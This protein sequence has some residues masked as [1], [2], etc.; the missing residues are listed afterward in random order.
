M[1]YL[2]NGKGAE[3]VAATATEAEIDFGNDYG[4]GISIEN[5]GDNTLFIGLGG[6][7]TLLA[8]F[9]ITS[10]AVIPSGKTLTIGSPMN[11]NLRRAIHKVF[12]ACAATEST[13]FTYN[14]L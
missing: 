9:A 5:T 7:D 2:W 10:A 12:H 6:K 8:D 11:E 13:T 1:G 3:A 4:Y 14:L